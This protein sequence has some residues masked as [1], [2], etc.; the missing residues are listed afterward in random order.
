MTD[1]TAVAKLRRLRG[2]TWEWRDH[3]PERAK[4]QPG[5]GII[6]QD[7][8]A[9]F[10]ELVEETEEGHLAVDYD[11]LLDPLMA[12][13]EELRERLAVVEGRIPRP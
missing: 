1:E 8:Q 13:I 10:P 7:V 4:D 6:A 11:G 2:V 12:A 3:A 9:V 5:L